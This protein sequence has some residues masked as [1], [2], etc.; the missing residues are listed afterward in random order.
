[1]AQ[2]EPLYQALVSVE[3]VVLQVTQKLA[4][5][6][7]HFEKASAGVE[8][9]DMNFHVLGELANP[10]SEHGYLHFGRTRVVF[11]RLLFRHYCLFLYL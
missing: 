9:L 4:A 2:A 8:V 10:F 11:V 5:A 1:M 3:I 7:D 6:A